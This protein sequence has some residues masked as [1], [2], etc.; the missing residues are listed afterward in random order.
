MA[1][2]LS[3]VNQKGGVG[4]TVTVLNLAS[5]LAT[6]GKRVLCI[7]M[8]PQ[9]NLTQ[10]LG[11]VDYT[12]ASNTLYDLFS[13][14]GEPPQTIA[15]ISTISKIEGAA[16][17]Y[18]HLNLAGVDLY[19]REAYFQPATVLRNAIDQ[20]TRDENDYILIDCP[21]ALSLLTVNALI[22]SDEI[23]I[24]IKTGDKYSLLG[25]AQLQ[26][27]I[28][29]VQRQINPNLKVLGVLPTFFD[30]RTV[31]CKTMIQEMQTYFGP[32]LMFPV[33]HSNTDIQ[34]AVAAGK[35]VDA[36]DSRTRGAKDYAQLA[37]EVIARAEKATA[38]V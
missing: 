3:I 10:T 20:V 22:A 27:V 29:D 24:P 9:S 28:K 19:L 37:K 25:I 12:H 38:V 13:N 30:G 11:T 32:G 36:W 21:P 14:A 33:I 31:I 5:E 34:R 23:I 16:M 2:I 4:K 26:K 17:C 1:I 8:D 7:D 6:I 35:S 15:A 18:S